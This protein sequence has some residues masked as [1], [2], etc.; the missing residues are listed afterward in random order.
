M[1]EG[2]FFVFDTIMLHTALLLPLYAVILAFPALFAVTTPLF[3]VATFLLL[4][5]H[6]TVILA[7]TLSVA[8]FPSLKVI[9]FLFN[10]NGLVTFA[11]DVILKVRSK[12]STATTHI[13][14][15]FL[16]I[17]QDL[18]CLHS[19]SSHILQMF[20]KIV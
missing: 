10:F 2:V 15:A 6:F 13:P 4:D 16:F 12:D 11:F 14:I 5:F 20:S 7:L 1:G 9:D 17:I 8:F 19:T 3:T 18:L